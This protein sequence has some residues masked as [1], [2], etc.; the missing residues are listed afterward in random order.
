[1]QIDGKCVPC[2]ASSDCRS[3]AIYLSHAGPGRG[4]HIGIEYRSLKTPPSSCY[5]SLASHCRQI[6]GTL[7]SNC[8]SAAIKQPLWGLIG[9]RS[10]PQYRGRRD[11]SAE[12]SPIPVPRMYTQPSG[13]SPHEKQNALQ[14]L[15]TLATRA[16]D[17]ATRCY[18]SEVR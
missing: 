1:M 14:T 16:T 4:F 3:A 2:N 8:S 9:R 17:A 10:V 12:I 11:L 13:S 6:T 5:I 18:R 7:R 15:Q